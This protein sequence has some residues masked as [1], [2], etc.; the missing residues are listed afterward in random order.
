M[1]FLKTK[2]HN[3]RYSIFPV[4]HN[5]LWQRY[6]ATVDQLWT[7]EEVDL[8][9]DRY[10]DLSSPE[11]EYLKNIL[12]FFTISD[13]LVIDN[14]AT[15]FM[16]ESNVLEASY[17][18]GQ[19]ILIEQIHAETYSLMIDT[20]IKDNKEKDALFNSMA[21]NPI[22]AKKADWALKWIDSP[23]FAERLIAFAC[24]EGISFSSVFGG[25]FWFKSRNLMPGL[26]ASNELIVRDET[27]HYEFAVYL[28]NT[29]LK[30]EYKVAPERVREIILSCYQVEAEFIQASM[31]EGLKGLTR[32]NM[33]QYVQYVTD[34]VLKD[35]EV[36]DEFKVTNPL[37]YMARIGLSAKNNFFEKV[38]GEY[39]RMKL[40][41]EGEN[42]F[43]EEF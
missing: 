23:S 3:K 26:S 16:N 9:K 20:Y 19:Q 36:E 4:V 15:N 42:L 27:S 34:V 41:E 40:P 33:T 18:Y 13:G 32:D 39:T 29:Y 2:E 24:V 31:P 37:D 8:S 22:V 1:D 35:F 17:Y 38:T 10:E 25:V 21:T 14:L 12:A 7:A 11:Q 6:K 30:D 28:Y 43:D 5:D